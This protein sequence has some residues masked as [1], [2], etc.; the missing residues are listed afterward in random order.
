MIECQQ[1]SRQYGERFAVKSVDMKIE[2]GEFVVLVGPSGCGKSTTLKMINRLVEPS[3]GEILIDGVNTNTM[4]LTELR[5]QMGYVIQSTGLFPHW[6]VARNIATVPQLLGWSADKIQARVVTLM[7][8]LGLTPIEQFKDKYPHQLSGGQAQRVGVARALA[9]DPKVLLMDEPFG[10]L[11]PITRDTLQYEVRNLQRQTHKTVIFVT[12][13]MDEALAMADKIAIMQGGQLVQY[14]S[15]IELLLNPVNDFVREFIGQ[16]DLGL[17]LL[18]QRQVSQYVGDVSYNESG[19]GYHW[20]VDADNR[21]QTLV[22]GKLDHDLRE[23]ET[24]VNTQWL[25]EPSMTMKEALSRMVW[26]RVSVLPVVDE[27]GVMIGEV[28]LNAMMRPPSRLT[29]GQV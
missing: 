4:P 8:T 18:S 6:T 24:Q 11:D 5:R 29:A 9:S 21:P 7:E 10:A 1:I 16:S 12:H 14:D 17:K 20:I 25:A 3:H 2:A 26:Y 19:D 27:Q 22:G 13:D 15:P 28:S 23:R